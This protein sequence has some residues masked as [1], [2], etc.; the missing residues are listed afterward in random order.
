VS[1]TV[2]AVIVAIMLP[3]IASVRELSRRVVCASNA[4]QHGLALMMYADDYRGALPDSQFVRKLGS[5]PNTSAI[6]MVHMTL[7][8]RFAGLDDWDGL[9]R[10]YASDYLN[11]PQVFYCPSHTGENPFGRFAGAWSSDRGQI[12]TNYQYRGDHAPAPADGPSPM[13]VLLADGLRTQSDFNHVVGANLL[14]ADTSVQWFADPGR[15]LARSLPLS[16]EEVD[17][18]SRVDQAWQELDQFVATGGKVDP[19]KTAGADR[20]RE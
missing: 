7:I 5:D 9:G 13:V 6:S 8:V 10:L 15:D 3:S 1:L 18:G 12:V 17:A 14:R 20:P 11:S 16:A 19:G 2:V 4:R